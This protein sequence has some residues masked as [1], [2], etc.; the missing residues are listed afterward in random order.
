M[1]TGQGMLGKRATVVLAAA[2]ALLVLLARQLNPTAPALYDLPVGP[3][4]AFRY[5]SPPPNLASSNMPP[6]SGSA[7]IAIGDGRSK[8]TT[9]Q[10]DDSQVLIF[11]PEATY[12]LNAQGVDIHITPETAPPPPPDKG[13]L[14]G[15]VYAI[16]SIVKGG[17]PGATVQLAT[18]AQC[19]FRVPPESYTSVRLR[20]DGAWHNLE[21]FA[22][23][24]YVNINLN[25]LGELA[26]FRD[27]GKTSPAPPGR[28]SPGFPVLILE[29]ALTAAALG[30]IIAG[31][32][33]QRGRARRGSAQ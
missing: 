23:S 10:T 9:V 15:N 27:R 26:A 24:D 19:L 13:S 30:I 12:Q 20:Y 28:G 3:P 14:V 18:N 31:V 5:A 4:P 25:H 32:I 17:L 29:G 7:T 1:T 2:A 21:F 22:Q 8:A 33:A 16:T 11:F 6:L